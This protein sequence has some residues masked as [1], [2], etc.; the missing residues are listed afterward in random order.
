M[1]HSVMSLVRVSARTKIDL[2]Q[3]LQY[4]DAVVVP[5]V[6]VTPYLLPSTTVMAIVVLQ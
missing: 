3:V 6:F 4:F 5:F 1:T 2:L